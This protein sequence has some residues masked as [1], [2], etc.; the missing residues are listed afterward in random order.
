MGRR[1]CQTASSTPQQR[2]LWGVDRWQR[3]FPPCWLLTLVRNRKKILLLLCGALRRTTTEEILRQL[4]LQ[5]LPVRS[6]Q[7]EKIQ[8]HAGKWSDN[9]WMENEG[10]SSVGCPESE[11]KVR[12]HPSGNEGRKISSLRELDG[13]L[14]HEERRICKTFPE[15]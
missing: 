15:V 10:T 3:L 5:L 11:T 14:S 1:K 7:I 9:I 8:E 6:S 2:N 13:P 4:Q 12:G